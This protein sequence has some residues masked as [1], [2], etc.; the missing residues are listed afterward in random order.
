MDGARPALYQQSDEFPGTVRQPHSGGNCLCCRTAG[1]SKQRDKFYDYTIVP[2]ETMN[3]GLIN[4]SRSMA[5][6]GLR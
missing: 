5:C 2:E 1:L 6:D 4:S 3:R